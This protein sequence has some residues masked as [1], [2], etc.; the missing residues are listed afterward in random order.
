MNARPATALRMAPRPALG[1]TDGA[2]PRRAASVAI[3]SA[4]L[5]AHAA[6]LAVI[7][8]RFG[9]KPT[10][11]PPLVPP[12]AIEIAASPQPAAAAAR[13]VEP[14][15]HDAP[16]AVAQ[17]RVQ[18]AAPPSPRA[19]AAPALREATTAN[20]AAKPTASSQDVASAKAAIASPAPPAPAS[21]AVTEAPAPEPVV[22]PP[23]GNAAYL[24]NPPPRYP[25]IAQEEGWEGRAVLRVHVDA[26]GHPISVD[27]HQS[28]GHDVLDKAALAATRQWTF[29]P[30]KRGATPIDGWVDVPL[31]FRLN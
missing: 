7:V 31:D 30:A 25:Q 5:L 24:R 21:T 26:S 1:A 28:S 15:H 13:P 23:I 27:L 29:V 11:T 8:T 6:A 10:E 18:K 14:A 19:L 22:T 4:S 9:V 20:A 3:W 17:P 12:I 2:S 16:R